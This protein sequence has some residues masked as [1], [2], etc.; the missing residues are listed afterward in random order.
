MK[1]SH[2]DH[3]FRLINLNQNFKLKNHCAQYNG[4]ATYVMALYI[5]ARGNAFEKHTSVV[6][7][8]SAYTDFFG[9][10]SLTHWVCP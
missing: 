2:K 10:P 7:A 3:S 1:K 8:H 9:G 4:N 6:F 5:F